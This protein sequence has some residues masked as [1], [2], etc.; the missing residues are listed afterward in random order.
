MSK[1]TH[2]LVSDEEL[3]KFYE[4]LPESKNYFHKNMEGMSLETFMA[5]FAGA[6]NFC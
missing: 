2:K 4:S 5:Y 6:I 3:R 1:V